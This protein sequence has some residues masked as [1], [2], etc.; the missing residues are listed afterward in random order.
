MHLFTTNHG[1]RV[2]HSP[3]FT[4]CLK[5]P[6][7][8]AIALWSQSTAL[9]EKIS[10]K[11]KSPCIFYSSPLMWMLCVKSTRIINYGHQLTHFHP[12]LRLPLFFY[13]IWDLMGSIRNKWALCGKDRTEIPVVRH[14]SLSYY[15]VF[16]FQAFFLLSY[17]AMLPKQ[18]S[19]FF[20]SSSTG[21][22]LFCRSGYLN[23]LYV[24]LWFW[25]LKMYFFG[26][27][28]RVELVKTCPLSDTLTEAPS[29]L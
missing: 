21:P 7:W 18:C 12:R 6:L 13:I 28:V 20:F 27:T 23:A 19:I 25:E 8:K 1:Q 15:W 4:S 17:W 14:H 22:W 16:A 2:I 10:K 24:V 29:T 11:S 3:L 5:P 9:A 26:I